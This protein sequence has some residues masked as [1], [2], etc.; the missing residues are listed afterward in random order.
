VIGPD[1]AGNRPRCRFRLI[2][3]YL[4]LLSPWIAQGAISAF[5]STANSPLDWVD[6]DFAPRADY[7]R[8]VDNFGAGDVVVISWPGCTIDD[9]RLDAYVQSL[10]SAPA[11]YDGDDWLF[12]RVT[13]GREVLRQMTSPQSASS[14]RS[15]RC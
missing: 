15:V 9:P 4:L 8:F 14:P 7:D 3:V 11:F 1:D 10:R 2:F 12:H 6:N 13:S 5:E